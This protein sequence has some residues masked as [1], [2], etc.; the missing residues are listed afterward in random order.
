V[1]EA[2]LGAADS[3]KTNW[4]ANGMVGFVLMPRFQICI[5]LRD[6]P[7]FEVPRDSTTSA[8]LLAGR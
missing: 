5:L 1:R 3:M 7:P 6:S 8:R 2:S 4:L